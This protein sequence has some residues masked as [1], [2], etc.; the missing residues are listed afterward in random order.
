M[1]VTRIFLGT[2]ILALLVAIFPTAVS[3]DKTS[4]SHE[5]YTYDTSSSKIITGTVLEV[6][7]YK[8]PVTGTVGSHLTLKRS[9]ESIEVH[10]APATFLKQYEIVINKGDEVAIEAAPILFEGKP[11][12]LARTVAVGQSTYAF[13]DAKGR[14]LW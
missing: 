10:L 8:C 5:T 7:D 2:F 3:Q 11:A 4:P 12:L 6:K 9:G 13:R 14:P 1:R